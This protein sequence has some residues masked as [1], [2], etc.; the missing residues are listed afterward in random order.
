M[1][2]YIYVYTYIYTHI[3][4]YIYIHIYVYVYVYIYIYIYIYINAG[5]KTSWSVEIMSLG[6]IQTTLSFTVPT[7]PPH[8]HEFYPASVHTHT[9]THTHPHTHTHTH[10]VNPSVLMEFLSSLNRWLSFL[11]VELSEQPGPQFLKGGKG[12]GGCHDGCK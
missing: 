5:F 10:T 11:A 12:R 6:S 4:T 3:Y 8:T 2:I 7:P 1:C 9:H